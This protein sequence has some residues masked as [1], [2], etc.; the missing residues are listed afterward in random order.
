[1]FGGG[2]DP[3]QMKRMM[4]QMG[5]NSTEI[6]AK[7]VIIET[8]GAKIIIENPNITKIDA[9]GDVSYQISGDEREET[10]ISE[11]DINMVME[12]TNV[13]KQTAESALKEKHGDLA[14]AI[15]YLQ[16]NPEE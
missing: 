14:E 12:Q 16:N 4:K 1:M 15:L 13:D 11:E 7:R 5:I 9:Q 10:A 6:Q 2:M 8:D 3:R